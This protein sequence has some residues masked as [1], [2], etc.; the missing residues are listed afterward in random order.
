MTGRLHDSH[1]LETHEEVCAERHKTLNRRLENVEEAV[2]PIPV[3]ADNLKTITRIMWVI[4]TGILLAVGSLVWA[5]V[6]RHA[7]GS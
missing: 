2:A 4:A 3:M 6:V 1:R 5:V 7:P